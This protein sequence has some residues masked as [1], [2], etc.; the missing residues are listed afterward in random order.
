MS[1]LKLTSD[2]G[3]TTTFTFKF[4][5]GLPTK[6]ILSP[7][8]E[9]G[10]LRKDNLYALS[11]YFSELDLKKLESLDIKDVYFSSNELW[12]T[13]NDHYIVF[14]NLDDIIIEAVK[15]KKLVYYFFKDDKTFIDGVQ[16]E[17]Y[18]NKFSKY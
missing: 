15:N 6:P 7:N 16:L 8:F 10:Y 14:S 18:K 9:I 12:L 1:E 17:W 3:K 4:D 11:I 5:N 13:M 2:N